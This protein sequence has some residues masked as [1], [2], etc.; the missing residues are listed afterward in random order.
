MFAL[1]WIVSEPALMEIAVRALHDPSDR[2]VHAG[3]HLLRRRASRIPRDVIK[4]AVASPSRS[5]HLAGLWLA[6]RSDGWSRLEADLTL[7]TDPDEH[8]ARAGQEDLVS[9][10]SHVAPT[11]YTTP[12]ADQLA[13]ISRLLDQ[14]R[15]EK[16]LDQSIR[17]HCRLDR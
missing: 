4:R 17:F 16:S 10:L 9:W 12:P 8:I 5:T 13:S 14:A 6:R 7:S 11:L 1:G 3:T 15:L 2:V